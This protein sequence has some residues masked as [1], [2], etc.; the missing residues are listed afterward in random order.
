MTKHIGSPN[1]F[2]AGSSYRG[3]AVNPQNLSLY[4]RLVGVAAHVHD[5]PA[6]GS[7]PENGTRPDHHPSCSDVDTLGVSSIS[8]EVRSG[9]QSLDLRHREIDPSER[10]E[11]ALNATS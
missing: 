9:A 3:E 8:M 2:C 6:A 4:E 10:I 7:L 5:G 1:V 11:H